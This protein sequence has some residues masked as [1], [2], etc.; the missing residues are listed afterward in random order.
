MTVDYTIEG[1]ARAP[2]VVLA[3]SL[4]ATSS[5]WNSQLE[6]LTQHYRVVRYDARGHGNSPAPPGP[7]T[8]DDLTDD[9]VAILD[10]LELERVHFV[11]L[12]LGGMTGLRLAARHP[13]RVDRLA[14]LCTS[15]LLGPASMWTERAELVRAKGPATIADAAVSRWYTRA[16]RE[17]HPDAVAAAVAMV[18]STSAEAYASCCDAIATMDLTEDLPKITAPTLAIAGADDRATP[19]EH[20]HAITTAIP[21]ARLVVVPNAAHL[22][23]VEQ[24]RLITLAILHHLTR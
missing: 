6:P 15:A 12:S 14:V 4:G 19:P 3:N 11:G 8:I 23:A 1:P 21:T 17:Q 7:Y 24:P 22:A 16:F 9:V 20:L 5:M 13:E 10:V 2:V 18:A